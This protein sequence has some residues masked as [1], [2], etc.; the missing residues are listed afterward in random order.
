MKISFLW[1]NI[2]MQSTLSKISSKDSFYF[3]DE[4]IL[5]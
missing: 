1:G 2:T 5:F 3:I 4:G